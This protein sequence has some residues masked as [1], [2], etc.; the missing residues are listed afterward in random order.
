[1]TETFFEKIVNENNYFPELSTYEYIDK[2][3]YRNIR[4]QLQTYYKYLN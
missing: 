2:P 3:F 4:I 1:M